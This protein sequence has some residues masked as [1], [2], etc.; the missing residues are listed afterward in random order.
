MEFKEIEQKLAGRLKP[1]RYLHSL[2]VS[3][4]AAKLAERFGASSEQA[5]LAGLLHDCAREFPVA[6]LPGI[7][8]KMQIAFT[9]IEGKAPILLHAYIGAKMLPEAYAVDDCAVQQAVYRHTVGGASMTVLDKI[10]YLADMIEPRRTYPGVAELRQLAAAQSL[11]A[12]M[13]AAFNQAIAFVL[14]QNQV[15]HPDTVIARNEILLRK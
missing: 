14:K 10:I 7:A 5:R 6:D 13:L 3:E 9:V 15:I 1:G 4:T 11:D 2:G 12:A 8:K